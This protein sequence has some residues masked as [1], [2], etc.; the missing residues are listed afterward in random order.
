[1]NLCRRRVGLDIDTDTHKENRTL[2]SILGEVE[3]I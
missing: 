2:D 1:M 3:L